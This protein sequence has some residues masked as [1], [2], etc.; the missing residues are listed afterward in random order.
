[1]DA[2][3]GRLMAALGELGLESD[4]LVLFTT[5]HGI[6]MPRAKCSVYEPGVQVALILRLPSR[7]G[8]HGGI[9]HAEM[10]SNVDY[11][12]TI[13]DLL[14]LPIAKNVQ[15]RSF[16]PLLDGKQYRPRQEIFTELTYHDY[17]D[18]RRAI[19]TETH[20]LIVNFTS[21]PA[22]M[23]PSQSWR[24]SSDTR[25][26]ANHAVAY[27]PHVELFDLAK[28]PF[29]QNDVAQRPQYAAVR[30]E[31]LKRLYRQMV[32]TR[33]PLLLGAVT[34]PQHRQAVKLL[35]GAATNR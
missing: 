17:Y 18:P 8:W 4:T 19:R 12:P 2:Q 35:E 14:G 34:S 31:L 15:G 16:A 26:P 6:A 11:L 27:H 29:E 5:D 10:V 1:V 28:D 33:D 32:D 9:V 3:F 21:A 25:T 30:A 20:K 23:D 22:F 7:K 24:P 13:L